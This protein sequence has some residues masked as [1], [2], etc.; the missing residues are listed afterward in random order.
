MWTKDFKVIDAYIQ[1]IPTHPLGQVVQ[2]D[3]PDLLVNEPPW[4]AS[5]N[6]DTAGQYKPAGLSISVRESE[7]TIREKSL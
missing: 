1:R 7:P 2:L 3:I 5:G 6:P 4:Q